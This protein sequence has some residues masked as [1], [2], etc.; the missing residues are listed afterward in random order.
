M[1][2]SEQCLDTI[3]ETLRTVTGI[4]KVP[5]IPPDSV[6]EYPAAIAYMKNGSWKF[7]SHAGSRSL[8]TRSG[9]QTIFVELHVKRVDLASSMTKLEVLNE[10]VIHAMFS[11]FLKDRFN[12]TA[13]R[14]IEIRYNL[15]SLGWGDQ[16]TV[17]YQYSMDVVLEDD[18]EVG[19]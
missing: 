15:Q 11:R 7:G 17:G 10:R 8:T 13:V 14:L 18:I 2:K 19:E 6:N 16:D 3:R 9:Q 1:S 4:E 12:S 5:D